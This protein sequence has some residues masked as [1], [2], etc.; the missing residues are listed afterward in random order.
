MQTYIFTFKLTE[1]Y[2]WERKHRHDRKGWNT[3]EGV[4][5]QDNSKNWNQLRLLMHLTSQI[6]TYW[7]VW[8]A[9]SQWSQCVITM[10]EKYMMIT[11]MTI[12]LCHLSIN[13]AQ[14]SFSHS[15]IPHNH[16]LMAIYFI[17]HIF[18]LSYRVPQKKLALAPKCHIRPYAA[19]T[20]P[21]WLWNAE[22]G[23]NMA[24]NIQEGFVGI[25]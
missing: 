17:C 13:C 23:L 2:I 24:W 9:L 25:I 4:F 18:H 8:L 20:A 19:P 1:P 14:A 6:A 12:T 3:E 16:H 22:N 7:K 5:P 10:I 21:K 15:T 11:M